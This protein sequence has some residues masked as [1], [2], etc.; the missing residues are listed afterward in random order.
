MEERKELSTQAKF[1]VSE[2]EAIREIAKILSDIEKGNTELDGF[3]LGRL[4]EMI[5]SGNVKKIV[6]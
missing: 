5:T 3:V 2:K 6:N 4:Y 1:I